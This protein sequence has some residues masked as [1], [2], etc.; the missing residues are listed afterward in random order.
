MH[1]LYSALVKP[2]LDRIV[3]A[4]AIVVLSPVFVA[5]AVAVRASLGRPVLFR[6]ERAGLHGRPFTLLKFRTIG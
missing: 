1:S 4:I 6:Q 5:I 3:A 2:A